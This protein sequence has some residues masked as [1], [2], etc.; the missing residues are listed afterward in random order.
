MPFYSCINCC[1]WFLASMHLD[2]GFEPLISQRWV[3]RIH[4]FGH[5]VDVSGKGSNGRARIAKLHGRKCFHQS[6]R[7][8]REQYLHARKWSLNLGKSNQI[9][10]GIT[11]FRFVLHQ[12]KFSLEPNLSKKCNYNPNLVLFNRIKNQF[13]CVSTEP[14]SLP[15]TTRLNLSLQSQ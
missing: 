3:R 5:R 10:I 2:P 6:Y 4:P 15:G 8:T 12:K 14:N 1:M 11:V 9:W 7:L 13:P